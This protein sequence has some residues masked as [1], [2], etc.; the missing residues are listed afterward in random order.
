MFNLEFLAP[1][2]YLKNNHTKRKGTKKGG[3]K[4][5]RG[6]PPR[7]SNCVFD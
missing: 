2:Q 7:T 3:A 5:L 4:L 6:N 1:L